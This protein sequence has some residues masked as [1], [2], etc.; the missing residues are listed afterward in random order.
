[1]GLSGSWGT[2]TIDWGNGATVNSNELWSL[3][4]FFTQ[5]YSSSKTHN[6][7]IKGSRDNTIEGLYCS[8][9]QLTDLVVSN[10]PQLKSLVVNKN[11]LKSLDVSKNLELTNLNCTSNQLTSLDLSR[12][13]Q[14]Q[15]LVCENN[16]LKK[17][18]VRK[19]TKLMSLFLRSNQLSAT[20]L[21]ALFKTLHNNR[22]W[23]SQTIYI[24]G[25]PG[26]SHC[27]K[28]IATNKGWEVNTEPGEFSN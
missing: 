3:P 6:I 20:E 16:E 14:L 23:E 25:N 12:N 11:K 7:F 5:N 1:I 4:K 28:S 26:A 22:I 9:N 19:N 10:N 13:G 21:D 17:L 15:T 27:N 2:A 8:N 24:G 18:D